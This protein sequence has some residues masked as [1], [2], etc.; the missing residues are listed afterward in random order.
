VVATI[1]DA[2]ARPIG[3]GLADPLET[4]YISTCVAVLNLVAVGQTHWAELGGPK[5]LG[6]AWAPPLVP[7]AY[8]THITCSCPTRVIIPNFVALGQTVWV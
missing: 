2:G 8:L 5:N 1:G 4:R 6:D 3:T 7:R